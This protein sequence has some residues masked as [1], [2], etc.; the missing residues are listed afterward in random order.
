MKGWR[1]I[2]LKV[3]K[4]K[5]EYVVGISSSY[6]KYFINTS[7]EALLLFKKIKQ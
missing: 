6:S 5:F 3:G 7:E 1:N 2:A 4:L